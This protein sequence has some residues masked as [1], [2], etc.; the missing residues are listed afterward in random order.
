[1]E[2]DFD[3]EIDAL[4]RQTARS[5]QFATVNGSNAPAHID[6]DAISAFAENALPEKT[7]ALY[8]T[9]LADCDRCRKI[10]SNVITLG[11]NAEVSASSSVTEVIGAVPLPWYR[12]LLLFPNLAYTMGALVLVFG[13]LLG[14]LVLQNSKLMTGTEVSQVANKAPDQPQYPA[15]EPVAR[16]ANSVAAS[17]ANI[18]MP[19]GAPNFHGTMDVEATP[20][21]GIPI[22]EAKTGEDK[23]ISRENPKGPP[24]ERPA[25]I[26]TERNDGTVVRKAE[27]TSELQNKTANEAKPSMPG[28]QPAPASAAPPPPPPAK[29]DARAR[30]ERVKDSD[31]KEKKLSAFGS[32]ASG[33]R[34]VN[35][36]SFSRVGSV[37]YDAAYQGQQTKDVRRGTNEYR[38]LDSGLRSIADRLGGTVV[39]VWRDGAYRIQ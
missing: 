8:M 22:D 19:T 18:A 2:L 26:L 37:W 29:T 30:D 1:M 14:F 13:G 31:D 10:L 5:E 20:G 23:Q 35:G 27:T 34:E 11:Q 38:K 21:P 28:G 9:H 24:E 4:L 33:H 6:A 15:Q 17:N 32:A 16:T 12:R 36:K 3:K 39:V 25:D 7:R